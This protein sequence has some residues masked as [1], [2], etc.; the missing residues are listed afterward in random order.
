MGTNQTFVTWADKFVKAVPEEPYHNLRYREWLLFK[1]GRDKGLQRALRQLCKED[2]LF[3]FRAFAWTFDPRLKEK[4]IPFITY[5]FQDGAILAIRDAINDGEN[6][7]MPKSRTMGASWMIMAVFDYFA[8]FHR[9]CRF[10]ALSRNAEMVDDNKNDN[11]LFAKID[12]IH[13]WLPSWLRPEVDRTNMAIVYPET[14]AAINGGAT[15]KAAMVGGRATAGVVDEFSR[16][17][18]TAAE[19]VKAGL[20]PIT[21]CIIWPF[22]RSPEMGKLHPCQELVEQG[23]RGDIRY[24]PMHWTQHPVCNKGHYTVDPVTRKI[25]TVDKQYDFTGY[26]FKPS[27]DGRFRHHSEWFDKERKKNGPDRV[28]S[29]NYEFDDDINDHLVYDPIMIRDYIAQHAREPDLTGDIIYDELTGDVK[30]FILKVGGPIKLWMPL[31]TR[32]KPPEVPFVGAADISLGVGTTNSVFSAA[33]TD[34]GEMILEF[35]T[36]FMKPDQFAVK[37]VAICNWLSSA[38]K[39]LICWEAQ[40]P[41]DTF[42]NKVKE[43]GYYP[44]WRRPTEARGT[45]AFVSDRPG[46]SPQQNR[47]LHTSYEASLRNRTFINHSKA[48]LEE[49]LQYENTPTGPKHKAD[50]NRKNDPSGATVNHGDRCTAAAICAFMVH[51]RGVVAAKT[52]ERIP[53]NSLAHFMRERELRDMR[54]KTLFPNWNKRRA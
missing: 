39:T 13:D 46:W 17:E 53:P 6:L 28:I 41:G 15:A 32:N 26:N 42:G 23:K 5:P 24:F 16:Y 27:L 25:E 49:T 50:R 7:V 45:S 51:E 44:F 33:R 40:G 3:W 36:P 12:F 43:M 37:C 4:T 1:A 18:P 38:H 54:S 22:T 52:E 9:E 11:C 34:T 21:P 14:R 10:F 19:I 35:A 31:D 8:T 20:G 48:S 29:A 47:I 30:E 2:I